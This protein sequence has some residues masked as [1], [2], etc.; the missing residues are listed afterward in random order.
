MIVR[1]GVL[2]QWTISGRNR[3]WQSPSADDARAAESIIV[4]RRT[5]LKIFQ[6]RTH[7]PKVIHQ[8]V[9]PT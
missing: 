3:T 6:G 8:Q 9:K 7:S 5:P 1:D 4:S 2:T